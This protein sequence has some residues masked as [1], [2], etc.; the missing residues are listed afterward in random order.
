MLSTK[1]YLI[2]AI[3]EWCLDQ[4]FTPY[5]QVVVDE[6]ARV[7][8]EHVRD[9]QIVLNVGSGATSQ[10]KL[11]N[12]EIQFKARF[13]GAV[14]SVQVPVDSVAAIYAREN[15]QGMAFDV[16]PKRTN[17]LVAMRQAV[18]NRTVSDV[19]VSVLLSGGLDSTIVF[20]LLKETGIPFTAYHVENEE[21]EFLK[22]LD[23]PDRVKLKMLPETLSN[24]SRLH[25]G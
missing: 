23:F 3:H 6:R 13:G 9:G 10:L 18:Q 7:P 21:A 11:G 4:G 12:E 5:L 20:E 19:P 8:R 22:Y 14:F 25:P 2:R 24:R 15:G 16:E 17:L 1:P